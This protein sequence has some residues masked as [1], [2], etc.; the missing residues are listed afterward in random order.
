MNN[1][2]TRFMIMGEAKIV[3]PNDMPS[4]AVWAIHAVATDRWPPYTLAF[5]V[6]PLADCV[7]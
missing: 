2:P 1:R 4:F 6:C 5:R 3:N 7:S